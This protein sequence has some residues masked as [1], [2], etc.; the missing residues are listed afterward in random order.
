MKTIS[1][2]LGKLAKYVERGEWTEIVLSKM[3]VHKT[4]VWGVCMTLQRVFEFRDDS[5]LLA[6]FV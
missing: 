1:Q 3:L 4:C 6:T 5:G 2:M